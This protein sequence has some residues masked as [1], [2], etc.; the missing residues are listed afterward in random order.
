M[1]VGVEMTSASSIFVEILEASYVRSQFHY[2]VCSSLG[3]TFHHSRVSSSS[4]YIFLCCF[5]QPVQILDK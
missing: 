1:I 2:I 4:L 5:L 3:G